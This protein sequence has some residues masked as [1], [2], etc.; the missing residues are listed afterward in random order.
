MKPKRLGIGIIGSG[1]NAQFHLR[2]FR[3]VRDCDIVGVW[4]P[5][6]KNAAAT[7]RLARELDVGPAK[8]FKSIAAREI[9]R[10]HV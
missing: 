1:F 4:S 8:A 9:G 3:H 6:A 10:A 2:A 5:N 7:A